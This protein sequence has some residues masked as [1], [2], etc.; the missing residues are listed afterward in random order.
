MLPRP[1]EPAWLLSLRFIER[2]A[3][4]SLSKCRN[5]EAW[6]IFTWPFVASPPCSF[7]F[8]TAKSSAFLFPVIRLTGYQAARNPISKTTDKI[9]IRSGI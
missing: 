7:H 8:S 2:S 9:I 3:T 6:E 4:L 5:A 1:M